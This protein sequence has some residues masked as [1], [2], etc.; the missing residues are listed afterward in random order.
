M[1]RKEYK[2]G[3]RWLWQCYY[4]IPSHPIP[5]D[6]IFGIGNKR[7]CETEE[8]AMTELL[9]T[10]LSH[11]IPKDMSFLV[12]EIKEHVGRRRWLW[13][14]YW[15]QSGEQGRLLAPPPNIGCSASN[16]LTY[17]QE[18]SLQVKGNILT[19]H[20]E[21]LLTTSTTPLIVVMAYKKGIYFLDPFPD[22]KATFYSCNVFN[23]NK[24][25]KCTYL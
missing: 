5:K 15:W 22:L 4:P 9:V 11:P 8:V 10:I 23:I 7:T 2:G 14:S 21:K 25:F 20:Q 24:S 16:I 17:H 1:L 6:V 12:L 13:Q 19:Y 18:N 3:R